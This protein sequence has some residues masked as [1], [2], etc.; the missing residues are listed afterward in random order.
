ML[1]DIESDWVESKRGVRQGCILSS[2]LIA[3]HTEEL[4]L[5]VKESGL[6]MV[7]RK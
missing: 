6:R 2:L 5:R 4:A 7:C 3:S 1:G